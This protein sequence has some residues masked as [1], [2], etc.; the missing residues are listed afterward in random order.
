MTTD[1]R[2]LRNLT[3]LT[4]TWLTLLSDAARYLILRL[5][6]RPALAAENLLLRKQLALYQERD[7]KPRRATHAI[8]LAL[9]V[10]ARWFDGR[11]AVVIV[12]PAPLIRW[13]R[14]GVHVLRNLESLMT[15][16]R[17]EQ[18]VAALEAAVA[19]LEN[20]L[21]EREPSKPWWEQ[22]A[23]TFENDPIYEHAMRLG[24]Q[25]RQSLRP[26]LPPRRQQ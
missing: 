6:P 4:C 12:Q 25:Y 14:L 11:Q 2:V 1:Q 10:L 5:H 15:S 19:K 17:L 16:A 9:T 22:I 26:T 24:Q 20:T 13:H 23:G 18:R 8:R 3:R 21:E 7:V